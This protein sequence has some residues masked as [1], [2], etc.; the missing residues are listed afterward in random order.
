MGCA[1]FPRENFAVRPY[2][3]PS[4]HVRVVVAVVFG[5]GLRRPR[6]K[7][8]RK[9]GRREGRRKRRH[10]RERARRGSEGKGE[11]TSERA[12]RPPVR[13]HC[14]AVDRPT[15]TAFA[16]PSSPPPRRLQDGCKNEVGAAERTQ[17]WRW[18]SIQ[19]ASQTGLACIERER[20][21]E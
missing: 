3:A 14:K 8:L 4:E 13:I 10:H 2:A 19:P 18:A 12:A 20:R 7:K 1:L 6:L 9:E 17:I 21:T 16:F 5:S 15:A 11:R